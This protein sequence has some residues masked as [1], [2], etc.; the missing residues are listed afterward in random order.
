M[1][2]FCERSIRND[3][4]GCPYD[5]SIYES[6]RLTGRCFDCIIKSHSE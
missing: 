1:A 2:L 5:G 3:F 4:K 6:V